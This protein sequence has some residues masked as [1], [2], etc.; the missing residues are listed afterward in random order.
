MSIID[1]FLKG[2]IGSSEIAKDAAKPEAAIRF[3]LQKTAEAVAAWRAALAQ[4]ETLAEE[5][6]VKIEEPGK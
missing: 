2:A 1:D 4:G 6:G 5:A 3:A